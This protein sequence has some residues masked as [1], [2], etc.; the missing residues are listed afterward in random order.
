MYVFVR[1]S[2]GWV[3]PELDFAGFMLPEASTQAQPKFRSGPGPAH[4]P[5]T[6]AQSVQ[7]LGLGQLRLG[8]G[9]PKLRP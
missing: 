8:L 6:D 9:P 3:G 1:A 5:K 4:S 2:L 7:K